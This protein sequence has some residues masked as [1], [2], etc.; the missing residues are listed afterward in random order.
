MKVLYLGA[1]GPIN[2]RLTKDGL[3]IGDGKPVPPPEFAQ[4]CDT[5]LIA[6]TK[7]WT[8]YAALKCLGKWGVTVGLMGRGGTPL[9]T[10]VPWAR[11][12]APLRLAQMRVALDP[13]L[14]L[15]AA[16]AFVTAKVGEQP[17]ATANT[18]Y[19]LRSWEGVKS[20]EYWGKIGIER[21]SAFTTSMNRR[22]TTTVNAAINAAHGVECV[23]ER[24]IIAKVG[25]DVAV[26]MLHESHREKD[27]FLYDAQELTRSIVDKAAI[28]WHRSAP[29]SSFIR[30]DEWTYRLTNDAMR[31]LA[32]STADALSRTVRFEGERVA[33]DAAATRDLRSFGEWCEHP[34]GAPEL[35]T[36]PT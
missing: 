35:H 3:Q 21:K 27:S 4:T 8:T 15:Q 10:F 16:R 11:H 31:L 19:K 30:D 24:A 28:D 7:G 9:S 23:R 29:P 14:R 34:R 2:I 22:A 20:I 36:Y 18:P 13:K 12:D 32:L 5:I 17:P 1:A 25:L 6:N 33:V 26:G